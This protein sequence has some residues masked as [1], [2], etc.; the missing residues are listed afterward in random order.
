MRKETRPNAPALSHIGVCP[1][2]T[3]TRFLKPRTLLLG[4]G[5]SVV[6]IAYAQRFPTNNIS[7]EQAINIVSR[8]R[9]GMK[10]EEVARVVDKQNGLS[11]AGNVGDSTGWTRTYLL[12]NGCF[13]D[14][15]MDPKKIVTDG[16]WGGNGLL[17][18]ASIQS[19][20]VEIV[21][22]TLTNAP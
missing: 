9:I 10:E 12:S 4:V 13:L 8:L 11:S 15:Q 18:S 1:R 5:L 7:Q 21:S 6:A 16:K 20:G 19:N 2:N 3:G 17:K 22:I 14:L